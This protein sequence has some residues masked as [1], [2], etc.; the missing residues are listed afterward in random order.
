MRDSVCIILRGKR[1]STLKKKNFIGPH[2][3]ILPHNNQT[4]NLSELKQLSVLFFKQVRA[5]NI[6]SIKVLQNLQVANF[7]NY[8]KQLHSSV[9]Q[10]QS[11]YSMRR[12]M[13]TVFELIF[14]QSIDLKRQYVI[15]LN[16]RQQVAAESQQPHFCRISCT[17]LQQQIVATLS[18]KQQREL[19]LHPLQ[20][21]CQCWKFYAHKTTN[22]KK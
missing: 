13:F 12:S 6:A 9:E 3:R 20:K 1:A 18:A 17:Y 4:H 7:K 15:L 16:G 5:F 11:K 19:L 10:T 14:T 8:F 21:R 22:R 2:F